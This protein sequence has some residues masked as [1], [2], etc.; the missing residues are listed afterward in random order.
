VVVRQLPKRLNLE[1]GRIFFGDLE[2]SIDVIRP[3]IVLDCSELRHLDCAGL[4]AL[5]RC[6][7]EAMKRNGDVK[8]AAVSPATAAIMELTKV[9][10]LFE[11]FDNTSAAVNS[12]DL[13]PARALPQAYA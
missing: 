11:A 1:Q 4:R 7:E 12:Y 9:D 3:R 2:P 13:I 10:R 8:L 5:L 6:L